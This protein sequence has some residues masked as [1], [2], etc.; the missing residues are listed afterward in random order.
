MTAGADAPPDASPAAD[1]FAWPPVK[2]PAGHSHPSPPAVGPGR[3]RTGLRATLAAV[4][5]VWL[6]RSSP[7]LRERM[8]AA[9]WSPDAAADYCP[10]CGTTCGPYASDDTGCEWCRARDLPWVRTVRLGSYE[11]LLRQLV[12]EVKFTA[13]RR[14]GT[15]LGTMLG[16]SL[17]DALDAAGDRGRIAIVP[18]PMSFRRR[19]ATGIDHALVM[20]RAAAAVA[21]VPI[22]RALLRRHGPTQLDVAPSERARNAGRLIRARGRVRVPWADGGPWIVVLL[23]DVRTT[24]ATLSAAAR[25]LDLAG[26]S[27]SRTSAD[28]QAQ[29][30]V[31]TTVV[32]ITPQ[33]SG[34]SAGEVGRV[35]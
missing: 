21:G 25:A 4:E 22:V 11:G 16:H 20:A 1:R 10:R 30:V 26:G 32:A 17:R 5:D 3:I 8:R 13:W 28:E 29:V 15:E 23:D 31:W 18:V 19:M 27:R 35:P 33:R 2:A 34:R 24:G 12:L 7:T 14:L 6:Q 9:G